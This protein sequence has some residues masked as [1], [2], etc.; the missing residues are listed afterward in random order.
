ML[1]ANG[2]AETMDN[3][4]YIA[5]LMDEDLNSS[6]TGL[7]GADQ[8]VGLDQGKQL[9]TKI[10]LKQQ[11][12][13]QLK[14][15]QEKQKKLNPLKSKLNNKRMAQQKNL[16]QIAKDEKNTLN[17]QNDYFDTAIQEISR[18]M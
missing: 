3:I 17:T 14:A 7:A 13:A 2:L 16:D 1:H 10:Q 12:D 8:A 18:L 11:Q 5:S 9:D 4:E 15:Q 6:N